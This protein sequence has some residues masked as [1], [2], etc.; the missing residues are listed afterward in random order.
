M[1]KFR[2]AAIPTGHKQKKLNYYV[3]SFLLFVS[4]RRHYQAEFNIPKESFWLQAFKIRIKI[5]L[6]EVYIQDDR[7]L[8]IY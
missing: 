4:F 5:P 1:L 7:K 6:C 3:Y 2:S 8:V